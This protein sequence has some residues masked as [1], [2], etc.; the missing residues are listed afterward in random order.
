MAQKAAQEARQRIADRDARLS[1]NDRLV[2]APEHR[3][4]CRE[5]FASRFLERQKADTRI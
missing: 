3:Q 5:A 1:R 4:R 2:A